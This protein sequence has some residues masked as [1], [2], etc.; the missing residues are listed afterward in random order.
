MIYINAISYYLPNKILTNEEISQIH[1]EWSVDKITSK[2]GIDERHW[3]TENETAGDLAYHAAEKLFAE[4]QIDKHCVDYVILCTQSPDYF[5]PS[6]SCLL[7]HRLGL[8]KK[9]GAFDYN[10]GCSGYIYG[11]GIAKGLLATNQASSVLLL[12]GETYT[13]YLNPKDKGNKTMF[14]DAGTATLLSNEKISDGLNAEILDFCYG[15]DGEGA[16]SLIVRNGCARH[17]RCNGQDRY[18]EDGD[19]LSN[20]NNLF[21]DGKAIFNFTAFKIPPLIKET[22]QKNNIILNDIDYFIFHQANEFM[23][24]TV[25]KRCGIPEEK[26]FIDIKDVGNTVS[27]TLPIALCKSQKMNLLDNK[28]TILLSGFGVGLSMGAVILKK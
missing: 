10:L 11:L 26:F 14:G 28:N 8:S 1:P 16:E 4:Y 27:N 3:V 9:C 22:L 25:R 5:L 13:K 21:M 24:N 12:T 17:S 15:T 23:L 18:T 2:V 6:T 19:F 7:Q 20:D